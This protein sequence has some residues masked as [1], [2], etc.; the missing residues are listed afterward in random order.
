MNFPSAFPV[1][2]TER[3]VLREVADHDVP[4]VFEMESD[5]VAMRYWSKPPMRDISE[6]V[7]SVERAKTFFPT[8]AG[9]RWCLATPADDWTIGHASLFAFSEQS[10]RADIGYGLARR[11]WGQGYMHEALVAIVDYAFGPLGLR[12]LEADADPRNAPSCRALERLGFVREGTLRE[13]WQVG[14]EIS[15]TAFY[16]LLAREWR[17]R[18]RSS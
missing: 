16:G 6:A 4:A 15:D 10:G 1:L 7:A 11:H 5:P 3:L 12:R 14:D 18:R 2:R 17:E 13:R 8:Q 9:L